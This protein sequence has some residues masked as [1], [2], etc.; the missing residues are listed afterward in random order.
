[1]TRIDDVQ[2]GAVV[3]IQARPLAVRLGLDGRLLPLVLGLQPVVA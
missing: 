2:A 3:V 1:M